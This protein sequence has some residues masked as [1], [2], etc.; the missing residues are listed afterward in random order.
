MKPNF[1]PMPRVQCLLRLLTLALPCIVLVSCASTG[2]MKFSE[3]EKLPPFEA[4]VERIKV[5]PFSGAYYTARRGVNTEVDVTLFLR[6]NDG[7]TLAVKKR[8]FALSDKL[9]L[10]PPLRKL[11]VGKK[12]TF[13]TEIAGPDVF[14]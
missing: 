13:P 6:K 7:S 10:Y 5:T 9:K 11:V 12:Y 4:T 8:T 14:E 1:L 2:T 3:F